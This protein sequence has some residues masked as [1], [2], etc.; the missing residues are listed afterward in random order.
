[1]MNEKMTED[2]GG[3][4]HRQ[5]RCKVSKADMGMIH[6]T[7]QIHS[8]AILEPGCRVGARTQ[9]GAF[10]HILPDAVI[11]EDGTICDHTFIEGQ[12]TIGN[13]ATV[14]CGVYLWSGVHIEDDVFVGS[15]A[16]FTNAPYPRSKK[17]LEVY[18]ETHL[19]K[20]CSVGAGAVILPGVEV[21]MKA[22]VEAGAVVTAN[23]PPLAIVQG[24]PARM[25]G[26]VGSEVPASRSAD[27]PPTG[28]GKILIGG[29]RLVD[30][31][32]VSDPRGD[33][34]AAEW[35]KELPFA[36]ARFFT[37]Y[38]VPDGR[39]RGQ[40]A[41]RACHQFMLCLNGSLAVVLDDG[42]DRAEVRLSDRRAGLYIPPMVWAIQYQYSSDA[43]LLVAASHVYDGDDYIR[44]YDV[45]LKEV[46]A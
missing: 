27:A 25:A 10:A 24:N 4:L 36:A 6:P 26:Y 40:H 29:A 20:G 33:L 37:V 5:V 14:E 12:V 21:G 42:R 7:A 13:R 19:R 11:G 31:T 46:N 22:L 38:D 1:M 9:V 15:G 41:H 2:R 18:P 17:R 34:V 3:E 28:Q 8:H 39:V 16:I 44:D 30:L 43:V 23:V 32:A 45:F 35:E